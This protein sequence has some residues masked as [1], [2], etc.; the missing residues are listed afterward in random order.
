MRSRT[1][2][3]LRLVLGA[4]FAGLFLCHT[5]VAQGVPANVTVD[6]NGNGIGTLGPG[7][8]APDPGPGGLPSVLTYDLPF[9][10]TQGDVLIFDEGGV[11]LDVI[12]FNCCADNIDG[13]AAVDGSPFTLIFY[14]D[15]IDGFDALADTPS[16]PGTFYANQVRIPEIGPEGNN[17]AFYTPLPG[18]PGYVEEDGATGIQG[19]TYH[20]IS[21]GTLA[22]PEPSST[23]LLS[24]GLAVLIFGAG[25]RRRTRLKA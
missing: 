23:A 6:E 22:I 20:F 12:R 25:Q 21:D 7:F 24:L 8:L 17:G 11:V 9:A 19:F 4:A 3:L 10:T 18:Q 5:A 15:N 16:P 1:A 13:V 2:S 14:S